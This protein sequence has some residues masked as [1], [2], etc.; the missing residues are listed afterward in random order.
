MPLFELGKDDLTEVAPTTF[1]AEQIYERDDLQRILRDRFDAVDSDVLIVA[2]EF[3]AWQDSSRRIDLLGVDRSGTLVV[4]ELKRTRDGSHMELQA[5]RYAAMISNLDA[6]DI[7]EAYEAYLRAK[8]DADTDAQDELCAFLGSESI[9]EI[10][11]SDRPR[12]V[13]ISQGFGTELTTAVLWLNE[14]GLDIRCVEALPYRVHDHLLLEVRQVIPLPE[15]ADYQVH[16]QK[17]SERARSI[18]RQSKDY[19]KFDF[20]ADG[21]K[22][23]RLPKRR[24]IRAIVLHLCSKGVSP[25]EIAKAI[26]W[27]NRVFAVLDGELDQATFDRVRDEQR[28]RAGKQGDSRRFFSEDDELIHHDGKTYALTSM[29]GIQARRAA[30]DLRTAFPEH[31]FGYAPSAGTEADAGD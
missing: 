24:L 17:K 19:T 16:K 12:I 26:S 2:E 20:E 30:E 3:G 6:T 5:L 7:A 28:R 25:P 9:D 11:I 1:V 15:A 13:L 27:R 14:G 31:P 18:R 10:E 21:V 23:T 29:W 8:G 22:Q 4:V